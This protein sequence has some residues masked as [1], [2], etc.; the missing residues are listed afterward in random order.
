[1]VA[2]KNLCV[3]VIEFKEMWIA[4]KESPGICLKKRTCKNFEVPCV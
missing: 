3:P 1:M 4:R 2:F